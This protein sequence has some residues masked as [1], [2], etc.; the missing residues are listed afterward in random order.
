MGVP[1]PKLDCHL[2]PGAIVKILVSEKGIQL[3]YEEYNA[4]I[5]IIL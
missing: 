3:R 1:M 4:S 2:K 5:K